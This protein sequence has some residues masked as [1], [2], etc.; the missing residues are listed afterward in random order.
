[1]LRKLSADCG[2]PAVAGKRMCPNL[3]CRPGETLWVLQEL[4]WAARHCSEG[5]WQGEAKRRVRQQRC[6]SCVP[7]VSKFRLAQAAM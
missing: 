5:S 2:L 4:V 3:L 6:T 1:M 7:A